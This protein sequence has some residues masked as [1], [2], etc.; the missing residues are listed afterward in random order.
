MNRTRIQAVIQ[1]F[2]Y[3]TQ[4]DV[5]RLFDIF[6]WPVIELFIWGIFSVFISKANME[7]VN[8][9]T[10][11]LGGIVLWTFFTR[12]SKDISLA[13]IDEM[14]N[15][16]FINLFST[17]LLIGEYI[18]GAVIV[19]FIKLIVSVIFMF[20]LANIFYGFHISS[21]G[22]YIIPSAIGLTVFGWTLSIFV[23]ACFLRYG[24]TV[25]VL[26]WAI[27][28]LVQPFSC[29]FYPLTALPGWAQTVAWFLPTTYLF[30]NMRQAMSGQG[31]N[32]QQMLISFVLNLVYLILAVLFLNRSFALAR[33][34]GNLVKNY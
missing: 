19:G 7:S 5:F 31:V 13:M 12:A 27:A 10:I 29:I 17:P 2:W 3:T 14:W 6:F 26:I 16:N 34:N 23:Q 32:G 8:L 4:R 1:K 33:R 15:R 22:F 30:E 28:S 21:V 25:E 11:L 24:H 20:S 9:V 18:M